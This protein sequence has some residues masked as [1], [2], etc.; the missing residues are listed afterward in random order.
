MAN[1]PSNSQLVAIGVE[2]V[3]FSLVT[4][5]GVKWLAKVMDPTSKQKQAA[6]EQVH[7][8]LRSVIFMLIGVFMGNHE[9][10]RKI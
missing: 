9:S 3:L 7:V 5:F 4:Y 10:L 8:Y 6:K 1:R 2:V